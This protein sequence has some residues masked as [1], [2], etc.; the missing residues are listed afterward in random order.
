MK[1]TLL[2]LLFV[3]SALQGN[4]QSTRKQYFD[5]ADTSTTS[6]KIILDTSSTNIWQIGSPHKSI[7]DSAATLPNALVTDT[8]NYYPD[9][10]ISRFYIG[11]N[12][13]W[14]AN[15]G[16]LAIRW[17]QKIDF[18]KKA[19]G[20]IIEYSTDT[21][22]TWKNV[23]NNPHVYNFYG[24]N[25]ANKDTLNSGEYALS[26]T[27]TNWRDI[28]L[29]FDNSFLYTYDSVIFRYTLKSDTINNNR[30][31]WMID[32]MSFAVTFVHTVKK[33]AADE[34]MRV[35]PTRSTGIVN[36][37]I[38]K[39]QQYHIIKSMQLMDMQGRIIEEYGLS[40]IK[41]FID[42]SN[43][44]PGVYKLKVNTNLKSQTFTIVRE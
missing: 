34:Y 38:Q 26:G 1:K 6:L 11:I 7:F 17:K 35:Y 20:G 43:H 40:P 36:V 28:W 18:D 21:G 31:G 4:S 2:F 23:F 37:E 25:A 32:N 30:E 15:W 10:N 8:L 19:D 5:G 42:V 27:D 39:L 9:T 12:T 33:M 3:F 14:W 16:I 44:P 29:C 24:F 41:T 22:Q 13:N